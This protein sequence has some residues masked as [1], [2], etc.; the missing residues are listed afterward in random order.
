MII[1]FFLINSGAEANENC[2]KLASFS[3][4]RTRMLSAEKLYGRTSLAVEVTNNPR[5]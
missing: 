3:N 4:G 2:L 5:L 1:S